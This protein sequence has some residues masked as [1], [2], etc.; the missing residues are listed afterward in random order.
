MV[1]GLSCTSTNLSDFISM[2]ERVK[3]HDFENG[4]NRYFWREFNNVL[5]DLQRVCEDESY[6][7]SKAAFEWGAYKEMYS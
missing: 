3:W 7:D 1:Q 5:L 6:Y 2:A 4:L